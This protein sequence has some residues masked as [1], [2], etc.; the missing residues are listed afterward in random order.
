MAR[1]FFGFMSLPSKHLTMWVSRR[2][3][4]DVIHITRLLVSPLYSF[5]LRNMLGLAELEWCA[6]SQKQFTDL[7]GNVGNGQGLARPG[8]QIV[9][10]FG[11]MR[12]LRVVRKKSSLRHLRKRLYETITPTRTPSARIALGCFPNCASGERPCFLE[13]LNQFLGCITIITNGLRQWAKTRCREMSYLS[14]FVHRIPVPVSAE[15]FRF[16]DS[17]HGY[18]KKDGKRDSHR[19]HFMLTH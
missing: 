15:L 13:V 3:H 18:R 4:V 14:I 12:H 2:L 7:F 8:Y 6:G 5:A 19:F 16:F 10:R 9:S 1:A 17:R 11:S